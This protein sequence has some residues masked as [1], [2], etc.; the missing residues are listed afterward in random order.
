MTPVVR[1]GTADRE[2]ANSA[3][4]LICYSERS[5]SCSI[6]SCIRAVLMAIAINTA[7]L[8]A[9]A[10]NTGILTVLLMADSWQL[11]A[12]SLLQLITPPEATNTG[13]GFNWGSGG[14]AWGCGFE[15]RAGACARTKGRLRCVL[16]TFCHLVH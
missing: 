8:M 6:T 7:I 5:N 1:I 16:R 13:P 2:I 4:L 14:V 11:M 9:I 3:A 12:G 10:I 15:E